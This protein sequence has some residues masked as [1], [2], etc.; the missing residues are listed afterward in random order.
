[1]TFG[2]DHVL[3]IVGMNVGENLS[4]LSVGVPDKDVVE[5]LDHIL[6]EGFFK[7]IVFLD[8]RA[9]NKSR[10]RT[11]ARKNLE[12]ARYMLSMNFGTGN[13]ALL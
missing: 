5:I 3:V 13:R 7:V 1:M 11:Q 6:V 8:L 2:G 10:V 9:R 4:S 12:A